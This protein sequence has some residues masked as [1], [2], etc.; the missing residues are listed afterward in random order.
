MRERWFG[1]TGRRV[2]EIALEG[3]LDVTDALILDA[4]DDEALR[5][6][7]AQGRPVVIRAATPAE[8]KAALARP[9]VALALVTD[10]ALLDLDLTELTYG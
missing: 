8:V 5:K 6:A 10:P 2:P 3:E 4:L 9:E 7:H 1:A